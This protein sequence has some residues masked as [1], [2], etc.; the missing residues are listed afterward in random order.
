MDNGSNEG[1]AF[2]GAGIAFPLGVD[3][4]GLIRMNGLEDH[5]SQSIRLILMTAQGERVMNPDFGAGLRALVFE[6]L[7]SA[8]IAR[9]QHE[10][11]RALMRYEPRIDL[12]D[13]TVSVDPQQIGVLN[14][15]L[16]YRVRSTDTIFNLV[17]PFYLQRGAL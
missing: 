9:V 11:Q 5:I 7:S 6:P 17:Y 8:T 12:L 2:L 16:R 10:V 1:K 13:V 4:D 14:V 15:N 3:A